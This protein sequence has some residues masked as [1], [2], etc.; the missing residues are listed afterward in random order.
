METKK[1]KQNPK[2]YECY[3]C[4]FVTSNKSNYNIH[5]TTDKHKT[6]H[7]ATIGNTME[8]NKFHKSQ[9]V[10]HNCSKEYKDRTGLW[11]HKKKCC[12]STIIEDHNDT[13]LKPK[14]TLGY[15]ANLERLTNVVL[16][17]LKQNTELTKQISALSKQS[18]INSHNTNTNNSHNKTFNLQFFLNEQCKDAL[19]I[20]DF[21]ESIQLQLSDLETTGRLGYVD[22][23]SS[24]F[25]NNLE[26][27]D[28]HMRPLHCSDSKRE[29]LYIKDNDQ[30]TKESDDKTI[31]QNAIKQVANKN[32]KQISEWQKENPEYSDSSSKVNDKYI[33]IVSNAMSG[34]TP[35]EQ[36]NN[37]NKII[38]NVSKRVIIDK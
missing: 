26:Q 36:K 18:T 27:L 20:K 24:I 12:Q 5:L 6:N 11:K 7:L 33:K 25:I 21:V 4:D 15:D 1:C 22:G 38:K 32:I 30:W 13:N 23:I 9:F 35:E 10:C 37:I 29:I 14:E 16:E 34:S 28:T 2:I 17:V 3:L 8:T 19:N 31:I